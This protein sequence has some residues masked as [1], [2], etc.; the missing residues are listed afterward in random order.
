MEQVGSHNHYMQI[1]RTNAAFDP[2]PKRPFYQQ[3]EGYVLIANNV[4]M[5]MV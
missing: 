5:L 1:P 2:T 4:D 3:K